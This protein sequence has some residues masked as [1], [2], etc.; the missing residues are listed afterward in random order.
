MFLPSYFVTSLFTGAWIEQYVLKW[1]RIGSNSEA[2][3]IHWALTWSSC[4]Q[5][6]IWPSQQWKV[7]LRK[8]IVCWICGYFLTQG[9]PSVSS[10]PIFW[11]LC[12]RCDQIVLV[13]I[14]FSTITTLIFWSGLTN[15]ASSGR[16]ELS[17]CSIVWSILWSTLFKIYRVRVRLLCLNYGGVIN[18]AYLSGYLSGLGTCSHMFSWFFFAHRASGM[19]W[20]WQKSSAYADCVLVLTWP[21]WNSQQVSNFMDICSSVLKDKFLNSFHIIVCFAN[22]G[23]SYGVQHFQQRS[24]HF[25]TFRTTQKF[26]FFTLSAL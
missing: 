24:C 19:A 10:C 14:S 7:E 1:T 23:I 2:V 25:W 5:E 13:L 4:M 12:T 17:N 16:S 8:W 22:W 21:R 26:V 9:K 11:F 15:I 18:T 6:N 20:I 3:W